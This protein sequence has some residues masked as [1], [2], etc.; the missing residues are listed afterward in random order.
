MTFFGTLFSRPFTD[1]I[2]ASAAAKKAGQS[3][4]AKSSTPAK[5]K[6][7]SNNK[8]EAQSSSYASAV[9]DTSSMGKKSLRNHDPEPVAAL[10][11]GSNSSTRSK[12]GTFDREESPMRVTRSRSKAR[13]VDDD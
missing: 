9:A 12:I 3:S 5:P 4:A 7:Q 2:Y 1:K 13:V 6:A 10:Q 11:S 8:A